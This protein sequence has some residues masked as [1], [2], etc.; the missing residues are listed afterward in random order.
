MLK[1]MN[2]NLYPTFEMRTSELEMGYVVKILEIS[3]IGVEL[4]KLDKIL[5]K[6]SC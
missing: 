5:A 1:K 6:I 3:W 4:M 2:K